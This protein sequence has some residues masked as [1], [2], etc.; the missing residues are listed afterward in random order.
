ML[1]HGHPELKDAKYV[2]FVDPSRRYLDCTDAAC[3]LLGYTR[4]QMLGKRIED[5]S[6]DIGA[7]PKLFTQYLQA[8]T[9]DGEF[10]LQRRDH[11][12]LPI[13]YRSFVF[14]DGCC[15][16]I[17]EP[18][19]GWKELYLNALLEIDPAQQEEKIERALAAIRQNADAPTHEQ[20][21]M[22]DALSMLNALRKA[23]KSES[24]F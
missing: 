14:T 9:M 10:V 22:G 3:E 24:H 12:P 8:R 18:V 15:A 5:L 2:V 1:A 19:G 20:R 21:R 13:R 11:T 6:Y 17:W 23:A 4:E 16:A 7:V